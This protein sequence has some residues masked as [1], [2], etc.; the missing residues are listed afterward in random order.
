MCHMIGELQDV[1]MSQKVSMLTDPEILLWTVTEDKSWNVPTS[2]WNAKCLTEGRF[3]CCI[4]Y[5]KC[6]KCPL[7]AWKHASARRNEARTC[8]NIPSVV[9][10]SFA[11]SCMRCQ[12]CSQVV[13]VN[14]IFYGTTQVNV[15]SIKVWRPRHMSLGTTTDP[16][17]GIMPDWP[18]QYSLTEMYWSTIVQ[19]PQCAQRNIFQQS[20]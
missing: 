19:K 20:R 6:S 4:Y 1:N 10:I 17:S 9:L 3:S 8:S 12:S 18:L 11:A 16:T 2:V 14:R 15:Y 7:W 13:S 5:N